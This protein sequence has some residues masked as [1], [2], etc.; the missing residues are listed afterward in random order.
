[1][2]GD[3]MSYKQ[4]LDKVL[5][6]MSLSEKEVAV[7]SSPEHV[8]HAKLSVGDKKFDA[9]RVQYSR[10]RGPS[11]GGIRYHPEVNEEE[12]TSLAFWMSLKCA[13]TDLPLGGG[14][15]GISVNPK[16]L[17]VSELEELSRA[18]IRAFGDFIGPN[19][20]IPAPDVYTTPQ[21]MAWMLDEYE[22]HVGHHAP[23]VITGKPL[24]VGGSKVRGIA[25]ALGGVYVLEAAISKLSN[26]GKRVVIQGFGNA[27]MTAAKLLVA[28]GFVVVGASDSRGAVACASGLD[29]EALCLLKGE[30]KSVSEFSGE[31]VKVL[32]NSELLELDCDILVPAALEDSITESN[33]GAVKAKVVLELA[34]G[35]TNAAADDILHNAGVL[36]LPDILANAG[37]VTVSC[38]EW[39]QNRSGDYWESDVIEAK[40]RKKMETA[41]SEIWGLYSA[42]DK[43]HDFRMTTYMYSIKKVLAA[44]HLRGKC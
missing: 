39:V 8:H 28:R 1:M 11:K 22:K 23:G 3:I 16:E 25:T 24:E 41:F 17:S 15:G 34:N 38:F 5:P 9:W 30:K 21:I 12:V 36:V 44:S 7:L 29:V 33:A 35:P 43:K 27:G 18:Y 40:L 26:V 37:G 14:K 13:V 19:K 20:D 6:L 10:A 2:I 32:S 42:A 4:F 31:G